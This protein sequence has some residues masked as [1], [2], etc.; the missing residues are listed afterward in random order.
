VIMQF[1]Q[2]SM[3]EEGPFNIESDYECS[4]FGGGEPCV[5]CHSIKTVT[6]TACDGS[7]YT[8]KVWIC[9]AILIAHN[10]GGCDSTGLC[11]ECVALA[12]A[13]YILSNQ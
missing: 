12:T 3:W 8:E 9:P 1:F 6:H 10:E 5:H 7:P 11:L 2:G 4:E 13:K